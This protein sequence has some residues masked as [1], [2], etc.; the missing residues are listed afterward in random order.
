M[1]DHIITG[2]SDET[3]AHE[4]QRHANRAQWGD[5]EPLTQQRVTFR[6]TMR[7][8]VVQKR[9]PMFFAVAFDNEG[10]PHCVGPQPDRIGAARKAINASKAVAA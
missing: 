3:A 5:V 1:I 9:G 10:L 4:I 7:D 2:D 6:D 8:A